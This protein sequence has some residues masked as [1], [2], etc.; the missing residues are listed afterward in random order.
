MIRRRKPRKSNVTKK[1]NR[2]ITKGGKINGAPFAMSAVS[3]SSPSSKVKN[4]VLI[5]LKVKATPKNAKYIMRK[6]GV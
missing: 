5:T 3:Y 4:K 6:L 1:G 2:R